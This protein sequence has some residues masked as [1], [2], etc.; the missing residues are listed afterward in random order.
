MGNQQPAVRKKR[1]SKTLIKTN[2]QLSILALPAFLLLLV[3]SYLPMGGLVLAFKKYNVVD[4]I[5]GSPWCGWANFGTFVFSFAGCR[6]Y[7]EKYTAFK[8]NVYYG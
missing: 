7:C 6:Q 4:G 8:C 1:R 3:F 2:L 5:F